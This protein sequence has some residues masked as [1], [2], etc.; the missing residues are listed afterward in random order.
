MFFDPNTDN[1]AAA[2][3]VTDERAIEIQRALKPVLMGDH[4]INIGVPVELV[5]KILLDEQFATL[6]ERAVAMYA[7]FAWI[8]HVAEERAIHQIKE[9]FNPLDILKH[10]LNNVHVVTKDNIQDIPEDIK[11]QIKKQ[12]GE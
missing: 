6:E 8:A 12:L 9:E 1:Y 4:M 7:S 5:T 10:V 3:G 11:Q 2:F